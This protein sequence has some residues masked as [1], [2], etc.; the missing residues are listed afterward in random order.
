MKTVTFK[1]K[2]ISKKGSSDGVVVGEFAELFNLGI[3][4]FL[5]T[6]IIETSEDK[7][8]KLRQLYVKEALVDIY[9]DGSA[10]LY[11]NEGNKELCDKISK[12]INSNEVRVLLLNG[13]QLSRIF[14]DVPVPRSFDLC[15]KYEDEIIATEISEEEFE[16]KKELQSCCQDSILDLQKQIDTIYVVDNYQYTK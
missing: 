14:G 1:N 11:V 4:T 9:A 2:S 5:V 10:K 16:E 12:K 15:T 13:E 3:S 7:T 6:E 8:E